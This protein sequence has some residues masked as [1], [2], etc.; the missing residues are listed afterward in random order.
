[1]TKIDRELNDKAA[2]MIKLMDQYPKSEQAA[3]LLN[4]ITNVFTAGK[5]SGRQEVYNSRKEASV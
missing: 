1:M 4:V 2:E 3:L 5:E